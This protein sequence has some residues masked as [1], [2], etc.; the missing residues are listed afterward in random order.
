MRPTNS[1]NGHTDNKQIDL[2]KPLAFC[3]QNPNT[4]PFHAKSIN[5]CLYPS[6]RPP[7]AV[8]LVA[9]SWLETWGS[10]GRDLLLDMNPLLSRGQTLRKG[11]RDWQ[12]WKRNWLQ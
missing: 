7:R 11:R 2:L 9:A 4:M 5:Y 3:F 8:L 1:G 10:P 6:A 12:S